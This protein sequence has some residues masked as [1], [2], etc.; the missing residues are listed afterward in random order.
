MCSTVSRA[1]SSNIKRTNKPQTNSRTGSQNPIRLFFLLLYAYAHHD[2][3]RFTGEP[4]AR[5]SRSPI[6]AQLVASRH[7][8]QTLWHF[9]L[10][11]FIRTNRIRRPDAGGLTITLHPSSMKQ[12]SILS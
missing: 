7:L 6:K 1:I 9:N 5:N 12:R 11:G 4:T 2:V 3:P 10:A 8:Q